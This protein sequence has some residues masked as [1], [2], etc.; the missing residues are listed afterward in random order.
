MVIV[1]KKNGKLGIYLDL[2]DL[3]R[4]IQREHY[5]LSTIEDVATWLHG[6]KVFTILDMHAGF[7]HIC[8][9]EV[10]SKLTTTIWEVSLEMH[11]IW[12]QLCGGWM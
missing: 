6:A 4:A 7:W 10:S 5:P 3:N 8:L 11:V 9:D 2:K 12:D 1:T